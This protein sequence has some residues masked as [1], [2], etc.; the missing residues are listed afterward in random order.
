M[1]EVIEM[2]LM[3][4]EEKMEKALEVARE[5]MAGIRTGRAHPGMFSKLEVDYYGAAT[6]LQQLASFSVQDART[7][8]ITPYDKSSLRDIEKALR[9]S[10]L[11]AN[12]SNDGNAIRIVIPQLTEERRREYIKLAHTKGEDAKVSVRHIRRHAKDLIDRAVK[13]G[14]IGEDEGT[15]AEKDLEALTKRHVEG[16]DEILRHKETELLEV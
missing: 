6:P 16:V 11:G 13:D 3:E 5:D 2:A 10:D 7:L 1:S 4:A 14:E 8:L 12:P 9:D 15:R